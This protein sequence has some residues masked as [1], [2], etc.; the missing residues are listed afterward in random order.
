MHVVKVIDLSERYC[1]I[2]IADYALLESKCRGVPQPKEAHR[3]IHEQI[4]RYL[5]MCLTYKDKPKTEIELVYVEM[6]QGLCGIWVRIYQEFGL[7]FYE[8]PKEE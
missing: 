1:C 5:Q 3:R 8:L 2:P 6:A 4:T 7:L